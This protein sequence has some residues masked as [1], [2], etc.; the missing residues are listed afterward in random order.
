MQNLNKYTNLFRK[1]YQIFLELFK[2]DSTE[3]LES[4]KKRLEK[5]GI[6][7]KHDPEGI[8]NKE[9]MNVIIFA[10]QI[11]IEDIIADRKAV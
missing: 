7:E 1:K 6:E 11:A 3:Y 9:Q 4:K 10:M 8:Y 5:S 2:S